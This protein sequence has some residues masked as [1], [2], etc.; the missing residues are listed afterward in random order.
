MNI[1]NY[2]ETNLSDNPEWLE[3]GPTGTRYNC[4]KSSWFDTSSF[5]DYFNT[6][7]VDWARQSSGPKVVI[8]DNLSSHINIE[9]VELCQKHNIS[10]KKS[11][12]RK[13]T[14]EDT[15]KINQ[16]RETEGIIASWDTENEIYLDEITDVKVTP[17]QMKDIKKKIKLGTEV[18][19]KSALQIKI[20]TKKVGDENSNVV[21]YEKNKRKQ[22]NVTKGRKTKIAKRKKLR[23]YYCET[24]S[25]SDIMSIANTDDS[26]YETFDEYVSTCLQEIDNKENCEPE[27]FT[28]PFGFSDITYFTSDVDLREEDW[29]VVKFATKKH[30]AVCWLSF[31]Y[32]KQYSYCKI[33]KKSEKCKRWQSD[34]YVSECGGR[35]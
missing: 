7:V 33:C 26:E 16:E 5:E 11:S 30:K 12:V 21:L 9:V 20:L 24:S 18:I 28:A 32:K 35:V 23:S 29:V 34:F 13:N 6:I 15:I 31:I 17:K 25:E 4:S 27:N 2:D 8:G 19:G 22:E 1:L 10:T 14:K 3:G